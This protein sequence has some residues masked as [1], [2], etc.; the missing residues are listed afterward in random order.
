M[1]CC[2]GKDEVEEDPLSQA[3]I[4]YIRDNLHMKPQTIY[5]KNKQRQPQSQE[6]PKYH[7][8]QKERIRNPGSSYDTELII[9]EQLLDRPYNLVRL[10]NQH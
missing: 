7:S 1:G 6:I 2:C 9:H 10:N 8:L 4:E 3:T 5:D